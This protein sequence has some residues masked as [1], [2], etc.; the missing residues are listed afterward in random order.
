MKKKFTETKLF[1]F[2]IGVWACAL[3]HVITALLSKIVVY[4]IY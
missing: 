3:M 4:N 2:W 1:W